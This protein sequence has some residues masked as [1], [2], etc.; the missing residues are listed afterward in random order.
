[1]KRLIVLAACFAF[2]SSFCAFAADG[3]PT[4]TKVEP[5]KAVNP[6][7]PKETR[8]SITGVVKEISDTMITV[9]RTVKESTETMQFILDKPVEKINVGDKVRVIYIKKDE[10][11]IA[12]KVSPVV[13]KKILKKTYPLKET[14][15][16]PAEVPPSPR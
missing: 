6:K 7:T 3:T 9:E 2:I 13:A 8:V 4:A 10:K 16:L 1:M 5:S 11:H 15:P 14:K 12:I